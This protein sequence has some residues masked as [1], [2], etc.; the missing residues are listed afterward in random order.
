LFDGALHIVSYGWIFLKQ[1]D[2]VIELVA[3]LTAA[4]IL[5]YNGVKAQQLR[6]A[7]I[8]RVLIIGVIFRKL[9]ELHLRRNPRR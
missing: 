1:W 3:S 9:S 7:G 8:V 6:P 2:T 4:V 5:V